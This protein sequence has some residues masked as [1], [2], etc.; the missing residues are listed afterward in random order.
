[1]KA[2]RAFLPDTSCIVAAVCAWHEHHEATAAELDRRLS[3][4]ERLVVAAP[5]LLEAFA[6][7]TRLPPPHRL[8]AAD[9]LAVVESNFVQGATVVALRAPQYLSLLRRLAAIGAVGGRAY[10]AAIA[11]CALTAGVSAVLT[12]NVRDFE[13]VVDDSIRV[14]APPL[15]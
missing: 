10:D 1:V 9:A 15:E 7:L 4:R 11:A 3:S 12:W 13:A 2:R 6:V 5:A 8:A 14:V